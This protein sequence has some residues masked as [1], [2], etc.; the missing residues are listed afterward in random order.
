MTKFYSEKIHERSGYHWVSAFYAVVGL[1]PSVG[2]R[3][4]DSSIDYVPT[5][6]G[7]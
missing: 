1:G 2:K 5:A 7:A 6:S 4:P 3:S